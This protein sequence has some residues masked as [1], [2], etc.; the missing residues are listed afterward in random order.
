MARGK[1]RRRRPHGRRG[2]PVGADQQRPAVGTA[3]GGREEALLPQLLTTLEDDSQRTRLTSCRILDTF[4]K[5][6]G[7]ASDPDA[8]LKIYPELLKRLDDVSNEVRVAAASTLATWLKCVG[9]AEG[10][11]Q[12]QGDVQHLYRELLV[13]LDDP[14]SAIQDAVLGTL[15][16]GSGLF[17]SLLVRE[18]E[19]VVHKHRSAAYCEQ[20]LQ[21][22]QATPAA[23]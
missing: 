22:V 7:A 12:Y 4:L 23:Q 20:L 17:P 5:S 19:A 8:F 10:R 14:E 13:H 15:K 1:D 16:E 3:G 6:C 21:H 9:S 11:A 2:L 18:T